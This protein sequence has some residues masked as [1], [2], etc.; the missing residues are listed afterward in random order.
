MKEQIAYCCKKLR[1]GR[2]IVDVFEEVEADNNQEYLMKILQIALDNRETSR[3]NRLV[4]QAGFYALKTFEDFSFEE[5]RLPQDLSPEELKKASFVDEKKNLILYG[6]V[7]TGKTHLA[8][9][10]GLEACKQ[11]KVVRFFRT[12]ALVNRLSEAQKKSEL[13]AFMKTLMKADL[14]ICDEWG[15]VP[16]DRDGSKLLFQVISECYEQRSV[17][18]T[19]NLEFSKWV[20][21]FYDEQMTAAMIDRLVHHS[22]LLLFEGQ[23]FRIRNSLMKTH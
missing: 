20:H 22:H 12:A 8:Q 10:I 4:K 1:L 7:G 5:I 19:T 23:S 3:K 2:K 21:I 17:I 16:L 11:N 13:N 6:N 15:Y 9:A 14:I 18:I